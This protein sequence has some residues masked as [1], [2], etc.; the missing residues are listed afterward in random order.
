M[1]LAV[2]PFTGM[3]ESPVD[4]RDYDFESTEVFGSSAASRTTVDTEGDGHIERDQWSQSCTQYTLAQAV[5]DFD[6]M[7]V[8]LGMP[9][10]VARLNDD[11]SIMVDPETNQAVLEAEPRVMTQPLPLISPIYLYQGAR[12]MRFVANGDPVPDDGLP[13]TGSS[14]RHGIMWFRDVENGGGTRLDSLFPDAGENARIFPPAYV[15]Q[16][17]PLVKVGSYY[18]IH[19]EGRED[20]LR[21]GIRAAL[22][23]YLLGKCSK[24]CGSIMTTEGFVNTPEGQVYDASKPGKN[25]GSH[26]MLIKAYEEPTDCVVFHQTWHGRPRTYRVPVPVLATRGIGFETWVLKNLIYIPR[27]AA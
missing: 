12:R 2:A 11:G 24:P 6:R 13:D 20:A 14:Y 21:D 19:G 26:A 23:G 7:L 16:G 10:R 17:D 27:V 8:R 18:R 22:Q 1:T 3:V 15:D 9:V 25:T 5:Q 4:P